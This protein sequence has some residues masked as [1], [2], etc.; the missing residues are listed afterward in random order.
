MKKYLALLVL[1]G[2]VA[3]GAATAGQFKIGYCCNNFNDTFQTYIVDAAEKAAADR[4]IILE[5]MDGQEDDIRQQDQVNALIQSGVDALI[6]VPVNTSSVQPIISAARDAEIPLVFVNRNPFSEMAPPENTYFIGA[7]EMLMGTTQME[8]AGKLLGGKG[9]I[10]ILMGIL[11]NEGALARTAGV[12]KVVEEQFPGI[13][14]LA[15]ETANWQRDQGMN[16]TENWLTAYG[17]RISAVMAN[18]DEMGL[19]AIMALSNAG[20][21]D[22]IV[23]GVDAITDALV[24]I[25]QGTMTATVQ[26]D[27]VAQGRGGVE[28][29]IGLLEGKKPAEQI[30]RLP[31]QLIDK[32]NVKDFR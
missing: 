5:V 12:H 1:A 31:A 8:Y 4:N 15:E 7:D 9:G 17:D 14:I 21:G 24:A 22:V 13:T 2:F 18:N 19:G 30:V 20:R 3:T 10:C 26:Q 6:V 27:P 32:S 25:E 29:A 28:L 11:S 23:L 16:V